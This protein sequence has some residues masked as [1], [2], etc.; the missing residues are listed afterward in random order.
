MLDL[1][2][3]H[4]SHERFLRVHD[5]ALNDELKIAGE[6]GVKYA[7]ARPK[8]QRRSGDLQAGN[9]SRVIRVNGRVRV[10]RLQ[11]AVPY[12]AAIDRGAKPHIIRAKPGKTLAFVGRSGQMVF[13]KQVRHPGNKAYRFFHSATTVAGRSF[14][15]S[16]A[17]RMSRISRGF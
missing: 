11:N 1:K 8:F 7:K 2:K 4:K 14:N 16:M 5:A 3:L 10:V 6:T 12:A 9:E 17:K 15:V 13:A